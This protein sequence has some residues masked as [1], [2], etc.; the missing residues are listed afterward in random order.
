[1]A[2][3]SISE[4][5]K[6]KPIGKGLNTFRNSFSFVCQ[7][8][9]VPSGL[10]SLDRIG[11]EGLQNLALN[12]VS[13]LQI[14]PVSRLLHSTTGGKN[15]YG[16]LL[17]LP[18]IIG[19]DDFDIE[20]IIPLLKAV[21]NHESDD[22]VW[23]RVY[24]V[25]AQS[26]LTTS[27]KLST[28]P[29]SGLSH[30]SSFPQTPWTFNTG[31]L[32]DTS[33]LR[34]DVDPLLKKEVEGN[35]RVDHPEVFTTFFGGIPRLHEM[36]TAVFRNCKDA[37]AALYQEDVGWVGWPKGC[38]EA[39]VLQ[40]LR[41]HI[42]Q[43]LDFADEH[44]FHPSERRRCIT[45]PNKPVPGSVSTRKL[46]VGLAYNANNEPE[47]SDRQSYDWSHILIPGEL[48]SNARED[49][50]STTWLD[51]V[52][53]ARE[54]FSA[55]DTR[56]FVHGFTICGSMMR[57]WEFDRLG[58]I[59]ST[60]FDINKDGEMF[61]SVILGYLWMSEE[62][63][64]FDPT[65]MEN[66]RRYTDIQRN[67]QMERLYLEEVMKRQRSVAGRATTCRGGSLEDKVDVRV[68]IKDSWEYEERPEEGLLLKEAT[69]AGVENVARY[70]HHETVRVGGKM[71]DVLYNVRKGLSETGGRNAFQQ[72]RSVLSGPT[73]SSV[74][75]SAS[76]S[77]RGR[78][79]S[80]SKTMTRKRS[81]SCLQSPMPPPKR[82]CSGS[83]VKQDAAQRRNR[84]HRRLVMRDIG[85][86]IYEASSPRAIL[87]GLLGGIKGHESLLEAKILHRD[88]SIGN[89]VLNMAE[90]DGFLI[91]LDL[92]I[93]IDRGNASGA[94]SKT[95]TKVFMA[96]GALYGENHNF[97]HDLESF[98]WV[99]FWS[100]IH[101]TGPGGQRRVSDFQTS[102]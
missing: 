76:S 90:D 57:L 83:P 18:A 4:T 26:A 5:I 43:F 50:H 94:P 61:V 72:R 77:R 2:H 70:Y 35:L 55:Q 38:T 39:A 16:D 67:G 49:N 69:E 42:D 100:C 54:I 53:Y 74:I 97:M 20:R 51:L 78:S 91:D 23:D 11:N 81:S 88:I 63:L 87:T 93:K 36:A 10:E 37:E 56:R 62:E 59:G 28:P 34:K 12:L 75:P 80:R 21:L 86:S 24:G 15:M 95:G 14:L 25:V 46:D 32:A 1:M 30:T 22:L 71:D 101:C 98:F 13:A 73:T 99:L 52:T 45:T 84:V 65:I 44:G 40:F 89:V 48:K 85:K 33:D 64:G 66:N 79:T 68:V 102:Q 58:A 8:L 92:A 60:A 19:S 17:R 3:G 47:K 29:P 6:A 9:G 7:D 31:S 41:R 96:I 27:D 82:S